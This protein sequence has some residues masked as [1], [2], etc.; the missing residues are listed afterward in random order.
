L[1]VPDEIENIHHY[2]P[3]QDGLFNETEY[4]SRQELI[5]DI[6]LILEGAIQ[7]QIGIPPKDLPNYSALL[8]IPDL[9]E[10]NQIYELTRLLFQEMEFAK[11]AWLQVLPCPCH[12]SP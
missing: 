1:R 11:V 4:V 5:G 7:S 10:K 12:A 3:I 2:W 9:F 6:K 8:V